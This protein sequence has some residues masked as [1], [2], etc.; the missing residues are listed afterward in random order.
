MYQVAGIAGARSL[1]LWLGLL[2]SAGFTYLAVRG[3]DFAQVREA[4]GDSN[5]WWLAPALGA[6]AI[7]IAVRALRWQ[8]LF[9][10]ETR[11]PFHAAASAL[12]VGIFVNSIL[13]A[14]A[15]EAARVVVLN[16]QEGTSRVE[17]VGTVVLERA[18]DIL[19]L[20]LLL[21]AIS[22]WLPHVSWLLP[23]VVLAVTLVVGLAIVAWVL[24]RFGDRPIRAAL[25]PLARVRFV[26]S[27]R[28]ERAGTNLAQGFAGLRDWRL[29]AVAL[30][31][32]TFSW[33]WLGL[34]MWFVLRAFEFGLSPLAGVL[35]AIAVNLGMILP[36][37]PAAVGVFEAAVLVA[38]DAYGVP[39]EEALSSALVAHLLNFVPFIIAGLLILHA[40]A[41]SLRR[42]EPRSLP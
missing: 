16:Q 26:D 29:L 5:Y 13:P 27:R 38:L 19:C 25:R 1:L 15:G 24:A 18:L 2:V 31:L 9:R 32:T 6:L 8:L 3:V 22:P 41:T 20:L 33:L 23:A 35:V 39:K 42:A 30:G 12:L 28:V 11:P 17:A 7:G 34:S 37:S 4:L 36:S 10:R 40:H 21:F 14:R